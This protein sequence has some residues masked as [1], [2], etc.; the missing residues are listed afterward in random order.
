V[1]VTWVCGYAEPPDKMTVRGENRTNIPAN[2][3]PFS[4]R[5]RSGKK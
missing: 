2:F 1:P 5:A 4:C 3:L